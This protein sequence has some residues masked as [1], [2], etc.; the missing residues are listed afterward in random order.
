MAF[1]QATQNAAV[2]QLVGGAGLKNPRTLSHVG[3]NP[4]RSTTPKET[5][6]TRRKNPRPTN[7]RPRR[8]SQEFG[9]KDSSLARSCVQ[10]GDGTTGIL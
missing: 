3:S 1:S 7:C 4:T 5:N 8:K 2:A 6:G 9:T 10:I